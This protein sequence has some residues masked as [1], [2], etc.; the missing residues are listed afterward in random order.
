[1]V[2]RRRTLQATPENE[3]RTPSVSASIVAQ[4]L[5]WV[6]SLCPF[7]RRHSQDGAVACFGMPRAYVKR[8][9]KDLIFVGVSVGFFLVAWF[10]AKAFDRL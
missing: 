2:S 9:M 3:R 1:M 5:R 6:R 10:Y 7:P 8:A 4:L